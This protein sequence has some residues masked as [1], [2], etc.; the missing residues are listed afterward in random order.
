MITRATVKQG[1]YLGICICC[2]ASGPAI[3]A[4]LGG[5]C[6]AD[7]EERIAELEAT[8][9]R[10]GNRK[11]SLTISGWV[12]QAVFFWDDG[13][14]RNAYVGTNA[15]EQDRV[16]FVGEAKIADGWSAGYNIE[17]GLFGADSKSFSQDSDGNSNAV[18]MRK[19]Y[20]FIKSKTY[21]KVEVG[22]E[23]TATYHLLDDADF[24]LTRNVSDY[25]AAAVA[26]GRFKVRSNGRFVNGLLWT[27]LLRGVNNSSPGQ[28]GRRNVVRYDTPEFAGFVATATWGEDDMWGMGLTYKGEI[29]QFKVIGKIGYEENTDS[30]T[31]AC[32][33]SAAGLD[34]Q[35]WGAA[36]TIMHT[37]T[38]LYVYGGYGEQEDDSEKAFNAASDETDSA[39]IVQAGLERKLTPLG[40][41]NFFGEIRRDDAGSN[42][43]KFTGGANFIQ[44]SDIDFWATGVVQ[45]IESADMSLYVVYRHAEGDTTNSAGTKTSLDDFDMVISGA[46]INF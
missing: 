3:A 39:W 2:L 38:G 9:A 10:K 23:G 29:G 35:W 12:N 32:N 7:L 36:A 21:G 33:T 13:V 14:E 19:A 30:N 43:S 34:C 4:D 46:K 25:E 27:D 6:C 28:N 18:G 41:T 31:S 45:S 8:T 26:L 37:P 40:N 44:H 5:N 22:Q 11:V 20:W 42:L 16:R 24:T 17:L 15:L 1:I